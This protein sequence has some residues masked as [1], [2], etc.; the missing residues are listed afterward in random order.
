MLASD[1]SL[2]PGATREDRVETIVRKAAKYLH[3]FGL[4]LF[5]GSVLTFAV[6]SGVPA[7]GD[8]S[9]LAAARRVIAAGTFVLTLPALAVLVA[10]GIGLLWGRI[11]LAREAWLRLMLL[12][13]VAVVLNALLV[14]VPAARSATALAQAAAATGQLPGG[15]ARAYAV[16][17][18]A[19][20][21]NLMLALAA[22]ACGVW[23]FGAKGG[24]AV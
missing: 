4:A 13:A 24:E 19:G 15:Y 23:R 18:A 5:V 8:L 1:G 21:V 7:S 11:H 22:A 17:S 12:A 20:G 14:V 10:S 3:L 2:D 9:S 16:E 6:A